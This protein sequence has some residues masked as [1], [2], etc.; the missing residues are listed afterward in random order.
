MNGAPVQVTLTKEHQKTFDKLVGVAMQKL[1]IDGVINLAIEAIGPMQ[2][3]GEPD[4]VALV[5]HI[6]EQV[7]AQ[8]SAPE[9]AEPANRAARR[10]AKKT[11]PPPPPPARAKPKPKPRG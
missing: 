9:P 3:M 10:A 1:G 11:A 8:T 4:I 6:K 7:R 5:A 2:A